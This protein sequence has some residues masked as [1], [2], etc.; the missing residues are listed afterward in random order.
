MVGILAIAVLPAVA[1]VLLS[2]VNL[3]FANILYVTYVLAL[4]AGN[5]AVS[6]IYVLAVVVL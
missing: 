6:V 3:L 4:A 1:S 5:P 2:Q